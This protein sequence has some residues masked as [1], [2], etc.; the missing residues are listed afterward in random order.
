MSISTPPG[1]HHH[2]LQM[3]VNGMS[4]SAC[5]AAVERALL[6]VPGV[7]SASVGLLQKTA[8]V[9]YDP[10]RIPKAQTLVHAVED[11]GFEASLL[12]PVADTTHVCH[13]S[14]HRI[15]SRRLRS[16]RWSTRWSTGHRAFGAGHALRSMHQ[17]SRSRIAR[18]AWCDHSHSV[19]AHAQGSGH[20]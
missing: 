13:I 20:V 19:T 17:R 1:C 2:P 7:E 11:C 5:S 16:F 8:Q 10:T 9:T 4:C 15:F 14:T 12:T 6:N 18:S 3:T